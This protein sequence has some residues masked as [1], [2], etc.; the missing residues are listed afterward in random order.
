LGSEPVPFFNG[1]L[2]LP[3]SLLKSQDWGV[4][5]GANQDGRVVLSDGEPLNPFGELWRLRTW[6]N[7]EAVF[8]DF[9]VS[10]RMLPVPD[11][12]TLALLAAGAGVFLRRR[13][14]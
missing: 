7:S 1:L 5:F 2:T 11:P 13:R 14:G 10:P 12:C 8:R 6:E 3:A 9:A 4:F